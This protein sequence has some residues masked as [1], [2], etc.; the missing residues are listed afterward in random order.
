MLGTYIVWGGTRMRPSRPAIMIIRGDTTLLLVYAIGTDSADT[1]AHLTPALMS[2][3]VT[4]GDAV[5]T[6]ARPVPTRMGSVVPIPN[7]LRVHCYLL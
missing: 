1:R 3:R 4:C 5:C 7:L 6:R 2:R